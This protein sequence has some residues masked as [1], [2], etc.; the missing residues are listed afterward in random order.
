MKALFAVA[1]ANFSLALA[2]TAQELPAKLGVAAPTDAALLANTEAAT[3]PVSREEYNALLQRMLELEKRLAATEGKTTEQETKTAAR[4]KEVDESL[5]EIDKTLAKT[6]ALA[7]TAQS[8]TTGFLL[9]GYG[10]AGFED[11]PGESGKF[12][13]GLSPIFLW[14]LSDR[15]LFESELE[16]GL[17]PNETEIGLEYANLSYLLNPYMTVKA[18][19][20][21][22]PFGSF[23]DRLHAAWV[24]K[25]PDQPLAV[26]EDGITPFTHVGV[27]VSGGFALGPTKMNYALYAANGPRFSDAGAREDAGRLQFDN[28]CETNS[29]SYGGRIGFLPVPELEL[30]YSFL[31]VTGPVD[32]RLHAVDVNYVRE[33]GWLKG[34][35]DLRG[36]WAWSDAGQFRFQPDAETAEEALAGVVSFANKR[37]PPRERR[38][39]DAHGGRRCDD[40]LLGVAR[41][42]HQA[43]Q[44]HQKRN[45]RVDGAARMRIGRAAQRQHE[46]AKLSRPQRLR[47][48][49]IHAGGFHGED[50]LRLNRQREDSN[51][52][53]QR[54]PPEELRSL[55]G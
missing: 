37:H 36:E 22:T 20:F 7:T 39:Q 13:A 46:P 24:N 47:A 52:D 16:I 49:A 48:R 55:S 28:F 8:G 18:G 17:T 26:G 11:R 32:A 5:D 25:L 54:R 10:F 43:H 2:L 27:Q 15:L 9:T 21:L 29:R 34:T 12:T 4:V 3:G 30:G 41:A 6:K 42:R 51:S 40:A 35:L 50:G 31:T 14:K 38:A 45:V 33:F 44:D 53:G 19:K 1:A 23:A